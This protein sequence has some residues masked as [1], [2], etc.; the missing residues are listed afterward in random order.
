MMEAKCMSIAHAPISTIWLVLLVIL[1]ALQYLAI[2]FVYRTNWNEDKFW[3]AI[4]KVST[5]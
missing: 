1:E 2:P 5:D 3:T 4:P